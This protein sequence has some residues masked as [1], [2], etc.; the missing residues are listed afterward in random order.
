MEGVEA[1]RGGGG[2]E[3]VSPSSLG[4]GL[5]SPRKFLVFL[6]ENTVF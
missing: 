1:P 6:V 4:R 5:G 3:G 2:G